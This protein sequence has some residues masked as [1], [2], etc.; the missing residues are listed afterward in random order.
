MKA[1]DDLLIENAFAGRTLAF[2]A[3]AA[4]AYAIPIARARARGHPVSIPDRQIA[5]IATTHGYTAATRDTAPFIAP[6]LSP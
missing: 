1:N 4:V 5:A 2:D 3:P 6:P